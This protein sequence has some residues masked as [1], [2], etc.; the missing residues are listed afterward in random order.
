MTRRFDAFVIFAEMRTGSN[1]L[2]ATLNDLPDID[3]LGEVYNPTFMG[4]HNTFEIH[5][6][7]MDRR[8]AKPLDLLEAIIDNA[9]D[10]TPGF[11]FFHDHDPRVLD[12][13]LPDSAI[14][15]VILTRN[16][17][18]SYVSRRI[19]TETGQ[20]R[21]TDMKNRKSAKI[22]FR[23]WE[24][25]NML[26]D[27][28]AFQEKLQ[29][30]MQTT[31]QTAFFIRY[32]DINDVDVVNGLARFLGS[33]HALEATNAKLKPQNP[34]DLSQKVENYDHMVRSLAKMDKFD[35]GRTPNFE[36]ARHAAVPSFVALP[37]TGLVFMP[38]RG[39]AVEPVKAWMAGLDGIGPDALLTDLKQKDLRQWMRKHPG[40][41]SFTVLR[42][43]LERAYTVFNTC[44]VPNDRPAFSNIR[45]VLKK[46]YG[47]PIPSDGWIKGYYAD[48]HKEAFIA[49]LNFLKG[50]LAGQTSL[51]VEPVWASQTAVLEGMSQ[52]MLP[53]HILR[54]EDM[55]EMLPRLAAEQGRSG[56][57]FDMALP[58]SPIELSDIYDPEIEAL[59][60]DVYRKDFLNFG[61]A[62][63]QG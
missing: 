42:H 45:R 48:Q 1:Y 6:I 27:L 57:D 26:A 53:D 35:L 15:K 12:R 38:I 22:E 58:D 31:G 50:N 5:G 11:R 16:P 63:W 52:F 34:S 10:V 56:A 61:F 14:A 40:H 51:K 29:R 47:L 9:G 13:V 18:E 17:L 20:W 43:P 59:I 54:E 39:A 55:I 41:R 28:Q 4:H 2:E 44:I 21:L 3:C 33:D 24:F 7:D 32:E 30:G 49:F 8:E 36:P 46:R 23:L 62:P 19:A 37:E 60:S 25:E